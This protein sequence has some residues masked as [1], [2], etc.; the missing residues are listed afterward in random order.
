MIWLKSKEIGKCYICGTEFDI[1]DDICPVCQWFYLGYENE[2]NPN[3][4]VSVNTMSINQAKNNYKKGLTVFGE[5]I[6]K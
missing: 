1:N 3:E 6:K 5:P 4:R 2:L